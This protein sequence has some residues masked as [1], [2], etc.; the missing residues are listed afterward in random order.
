MNIILVYCQT[1]HQSNDRISPQHCKKLIYG[2]PKQII[3]SYKKNKYEIIKLKKN[4][5]LTMKIS[6]IMLAYKRN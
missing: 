5:S 4:I 6:P 3:K 2:Q 1:E